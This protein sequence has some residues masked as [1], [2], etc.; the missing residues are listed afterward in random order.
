MLFAGF[1]F[2][3]VIVIVV[4]F[5]VGRSDLDEIWAAISQ[6]KGVET[7]ESVGY[8]NVNASE[9]VESPEGVMGYLFLKEELLDLERSAESPEIIVR[10]NRMRA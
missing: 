4:V 6:F 3:V 1:A 7:A 9:C 10:P 8:V 5:L 2:L